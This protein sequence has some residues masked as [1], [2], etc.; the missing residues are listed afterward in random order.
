VQYDES[1]VLREEQRFGRTMRSLGRPGKAL[2]GV[3]K[4]V[5]KPGQQESRYGPVP[6][7]EGCGEER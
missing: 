4:V 1:G 6:G 5:V 7:A 3:E 2:F